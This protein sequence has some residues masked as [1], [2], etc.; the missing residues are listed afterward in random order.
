MD[1][2]IEILQT[3]TIILLYY[4]TKIFGKRIKNIES[5]LD[6]NES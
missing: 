4:L 1:M 2:V 3:I 6:E 5:E